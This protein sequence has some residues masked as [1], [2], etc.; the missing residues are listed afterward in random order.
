LLPAGRLNAGAARVRCDWDGCGHVQGEG[1]AVTAARRRERSG[2]AG[3]R[4]AADARWMAMALRLAHLGCGTT[5]PNPR[6]GAVAVRG[7]R[8]VGAGAHLAFGG[9]HAEAFLLSA[10]RRAELAG[11]TL[12]VTLE[13]CA[14][15]GKTPACAPALVAARL[16]RVVAAIEDPDPH[17]CGKGFAILRAGGL[18]VVSGVMARR[19][20][21]VNA[22]FLW[23]RHSGL[24][25]MTL[26]VAAS[27]DGRIA[28][29]DGTNRWVSGEAARACVHRWRSEAD[30]I[31]TGR[32][33]LVTDRPRLSAR[34]RRDPLAALR[35][36]MGVAGGGRHQPV[37]IVVDS[38]CRTGA[39]D[40]L[41]A[42]MAESPGGRWVLACGARAPRAARKRAERHGVEIWTLSGQRGG[43]GVDLLSLA[44]EMAQRGLLDV[45]VESGPTLA[46]SLVQAGLVGRLRVFHAPLLLGGAWTW[47]RRLGDDVLTEAWHADVE[48][49]LAETVRRSEGG[50]LGVAATC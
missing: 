22:P 10:A 49:C 45:L 43:G 38:R 2:P 6:V 20:A 21:E 23:H 42:H 30:A 44:R 17:V 47:V 28:A 31:L 14:H 39:D 24:P 34:L 15:R 37:R 7:G 26:K 50:R 4:D 8:C 3:Q 35:R 11:A 29:G 48:R 27:L 25:L 9:P 1:I 40:E 19:A 18:E 12:Y 46:S 36:R 32:G 16:R 5:H 41:L 13:P 33:T